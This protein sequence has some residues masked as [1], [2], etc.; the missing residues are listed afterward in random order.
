MTFADSDEW[1][2]YVSKGNNHVMEAH[3]QDGYLLAAV[4]SLGMFG[5]G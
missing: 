3:S 4:L 5:G 2:N 1:Q